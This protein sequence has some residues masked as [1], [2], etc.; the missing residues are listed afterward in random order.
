[1]KSW[2]Y[3]LA[4]AMVGAFS[5]CGKAQAIPITYSYYGAVS[6]H[7]YRDFSSSVPVGTHVSWSI[8]FEEGIS[9]GSVT[10]AD[11]N[12]GA[13]SGWLHLGSRAYVL[14]TGRIGILG[15]DGLGNVD[16]AQFRFSGSG[17]DIDGGVFYGLFVSLTSALNPFGNPAIGYG[18]PEPP[19]FTGYGYLALAGQASVQ[20]HGVPEPG[21]I[22]LLG[23]ALAALVVVD[24][25]RRTPLASTRP[26]E[27]LL[28]SA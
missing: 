1:M 28:R 13:V 21:S 2:M 23:L 26:V 9:D 22:G 17:P 25:R 16:W 11:L 27:A 3:S 24:R 14:N 19:H 8:N 7:L 15:Y 12:A 4:L 10:A 6:E 5:W 18:F 20:R